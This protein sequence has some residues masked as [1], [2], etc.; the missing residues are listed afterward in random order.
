MDFKVPTEEEY[1]YALA[2]G[3]EEDMWYNFDLRTVFLSKTR[4]EEDYLDEN[5]VGSVF[6]Q[7]NHEVIH[8]IIQKLEGKDTSLDLDDL[9]SFTPNF[10]RIYLF[11]I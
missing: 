10:H 8:G 7:L 4:P 5:E 1:C 3:I 2:E 6:N 9:I 11:A